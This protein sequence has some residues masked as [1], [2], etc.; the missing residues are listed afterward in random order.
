M[1]C[2]GAQCYK[3]IDNFGGEHV[4]LLTREE[5]DTKSFGGSGI[6]DGRRE[7]QES[8]A[9]VRGLGLQGLGLLPAR[10]WLW[11][12]ELM[13]TSASAASR[14]VYSR[15]DVPLASDCSLSCRLLFE[16]GPQ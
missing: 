16:Y 5:R 1:P 3:P 15:P 2:L 14:S 13:H 12:Q 10:K 11:P 6:S 8:E 4:E 9:G 7:S